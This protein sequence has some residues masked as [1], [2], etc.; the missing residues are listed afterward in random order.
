M[1]QYAAFFLFCCSLT[2]IK[3]C[4]PGEDNF[5]HVSYHDKITRV[6]VRGV[7]GFVL[8][9]QDHG[10]IAGQP[11]DDLVGRVDQPPLLLDFAGLGHVR[12]GYCHFRPLTLMGAGPAAPASRS[13]LPGNAAAGAR[14]THT[15]LAYRQP[16]KASGGEAAEKTEQITP[17]Q[18]GGFSLT[19]LRVIIAANPA[20][21]ARRG[22]FQHD[23]R[24]LSRNVPR[25]E[26][27]RAD[28]GLAADAP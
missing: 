5:L 16:D 1:Q 4:R 6:D 2:L 26:P 20:N 28:P 21:S 8:A 22:H 3:N 7:D 15:L 18:L 14:Q 10:D 25:R 9:H 11:A 17:A 12:F 19:V 23:C 24:C 27:R 13:Q